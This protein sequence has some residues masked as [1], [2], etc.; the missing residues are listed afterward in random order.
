[1]KPHLI[2]KIGVGYELFS[3]YLVTPLK[4]RDLP[5]VL[6]FRQLVSSCLHALGH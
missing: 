1:M 2:F 4:G 5:L 3:K 6:P